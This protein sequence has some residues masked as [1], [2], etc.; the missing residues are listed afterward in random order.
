VQDEAQAKKIIAD[1]KKGAKFDDLA[2]KQSKDPGSAQKGGD[3]DWA[4]PSSFV[5]EFAEAMVKLGKGQMTQEPVK[6]NFGW[7]VIRVDDVRE[8]QLP[9]LDE[10]KPQ[11]AQQLQQ[12]KLAKFQEELRGKAKIE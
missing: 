10:I 3:L 11:I 9:K 4:T 12:Q 7:H 5:P 6:S 8:A 1:L 2:K